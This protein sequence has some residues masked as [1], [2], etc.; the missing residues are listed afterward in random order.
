ML[1]VIEAR[2]VSG[3]LITVDQALEQGKDVLALPGRVGDPLSEG[4]NHLIRQGAGIL[5][6]TD[7]V[8]QL[9]GMQAEPDG[10]S[11]LKGAEAAPAD[12]LSEQEKKVLGLLSHDPMHLE[13]L[14]KR[15]G[16]GLGTLSLILLSL[17]ERGLVKPVSGNQYIRVF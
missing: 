12:R 14:M 17:E 6:G 4:C 9:L 15:T 16:L 10:T 7:E 1:L 13:E 2:K 5:T 3:T 11:A 8:L